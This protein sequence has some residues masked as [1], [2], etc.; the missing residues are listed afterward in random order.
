MFHL[1]FKEPNL[2]RWAFLFK[3]IAQLFG[4]YKYNTYLC[5]MKTD[6]QII[7]RMIDNEEARK[8]KV[9][10]GRIFGVNGVQGDP[11]K[12]LGYKDSP[13]YVKLKE[14]KKDLTGSLLK[15]DGDLLFY[16]DEVSEEG[17]FTKLYLFANDVNDY[18]KRENFP[19]NLTELC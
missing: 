17:G 10:S 6:K 1:R 18:V 19:Q 11:K 3:I 13:I 7:S 5:S 12:R 16:V 14:A 4:Y 15:G 9:E 2:A 8:S